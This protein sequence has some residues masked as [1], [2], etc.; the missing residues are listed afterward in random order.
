MIVLAKRN[1]ASRGYVVDMFV[2]TCFCGEMSNLTSIFLNGWKRRNN[3]E[4]ECVCFHMPN[5][6]AMYISIYTHIGHCDDL[7]APGYTLE[8]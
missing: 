6:Y 1:V 3:I 4:S 5:K 2:L 8:D 7:L